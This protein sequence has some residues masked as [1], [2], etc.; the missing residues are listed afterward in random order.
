MLSIRPEQLSKEAAG[1]L[2]AKLLREWL[3]LLCEQLEFP[4]G[5]FLRLASP[6]PR[7]GEK[8][9]PWIQQLKDLSQDQTQ[10]LAGTQVSQPGPTRRRDLLRAVPLAVERC[11]ARLWDGRN[12]QTGPPPPADFLDT[13]AIF[14][15]ATAQI[16]IP[17]TLGW[18]AT[19]FRSYVN[20]VAWTS[21]CMTRGRSF[22]REGIG[23]RDLEAE[24]TRS[25]AELGRLTRCE[26]GGGLVA[27]TL[28]NG[29]LDRLKLYLDGIV[30][31]RPMFEP[32]SAF[33]QIGL[34]DLPDLAARTDYAI[35]M[36]G[37]EHLPQLFEQGLAQLW[38][39]LGT[40][41]VESERGSGDAD[42]AATFSLLR[43]EEYSF[44]VA[45]KST[46]R[47]YSFPTKDRRALTEYV[48]GVR[49]EL[50]EHEPRFVLICG[51][52][53]TGTLTLKLELF[54]AELQV[55]VRY[56]TATV[57]ASLRDEISG[58][59]DPELLLET[60]RLPGA[61]LTDEKIQEL[62]KA[63]RLD[64]IDHVNPARFAF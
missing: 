25:L 53:P 5:D 46:H 40:S 2:C 18:D 17:A 28:L 16:A 64:Q 35:D 7:D 33:A 11:V 8:P 27:A 1:S 38:A 51:P 32:R 39:T 60:V 19:L 37:D 41:I 63:I 55:P 10:P 47:R 15:S 34:R 56:C 20:A 50:P 57:L 3:H 12:L 52:T 45:A 36:Y 4:S 21:A 54:S 23:V 6:R 58:T 22:T 62:I 24:V 44:L 29:S 59:I 48:R 30:A 26:P 14:S 31:S 9:Q 42:T 49:H 13:L 43:T 61:I